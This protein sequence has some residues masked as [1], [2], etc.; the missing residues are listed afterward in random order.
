[1][2]FGINFYSICGIISLKEIMTTIYI[3]LLKAIGF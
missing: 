1:M 3:A 2:N